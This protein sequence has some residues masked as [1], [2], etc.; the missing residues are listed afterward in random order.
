MESYA[1]L[2]ATAEPQLTDMV[3]NVQRVDETELV[4]VN[5]QEKQEEEEAIEMR[6]RVRGKGNCAGN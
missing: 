4:E 5:C 6:N 2:R 3:D 1:N